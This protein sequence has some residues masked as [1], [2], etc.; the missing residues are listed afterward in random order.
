MV[1]NTTA[2]HEALVS[3]CRSVFLGL[4]IITNFSRKVAVDSL[5][6]TWDFN[7]TAEVWVYY[8]GTPLSKP[9]GIT[10]VV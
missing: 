2:E 8:Y 1:E 10:K 6:F 7:V 4:F 3:I 9:S 5:L